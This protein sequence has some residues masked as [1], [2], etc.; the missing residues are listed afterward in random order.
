[1]YQEE[2]FTR[3]NANAKF[4]GAGCNAAAWAVCDDW[5]IKVAQRRDGTLNY[6]EWCVRMTAAG[7]KMKGMPEIDRIAHTSGGYVAYM[8]LYAS[9]GE[10]VESLGRYD[11]YEGYLLELVDAYEAYAKTVLDDTAGCCDLHSGNIMFDRPN[12]CYVITDP[13]ASSYAVAPYVEFTLQ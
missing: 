2:M 13:T 3:P 11:V 8:R 12:G 6:L 4:L 10:G 9:S 7:N 1:M 5:A